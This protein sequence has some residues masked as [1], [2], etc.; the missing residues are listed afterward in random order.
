[1]YLHARTFC[2]LAHTTS[3]PVS[4]MYLPARTF[5]TLSDTI[6]YPLQ[7]TIFTVI[8]EVSPRANRAVVTNNLSM[9]IE[10]MLI[11]IMF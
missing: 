10:V 6:L 3:I 9:I 5:C 7:A 11:D 1:M 4:A 2:T 8:T